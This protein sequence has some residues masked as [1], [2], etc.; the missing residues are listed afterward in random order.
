[1]DGNDHSVVL[2][3]H[4]KDKSFSKIMEDNNIKTLE[5]ALICGELWN[6]NNGIT[7]CKKCHKQKHVRI[8]K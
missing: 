3:A 6:I 4:H 8:S 2:N 5:E 7:Y 1:L